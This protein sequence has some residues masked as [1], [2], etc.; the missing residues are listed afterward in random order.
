M[1]L[2]E[3]GVLLHDLSSTDA[4]FQA[5]DVPLDDFKV[6][7]QGLELELEDS[8]LMLKNSVVVLLVV[9][10]DVQVDQLFDLHLFEDVFLVNAGF[11]LFIAEAAGLE[12]GHQ[13][14]VEAECSILVLDAG[15]VIHCVVALE[16]GVLSA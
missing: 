4:F 12:F 15:V 1:L 14:V 9:R 8:I 11:V 10:G 6:L 5:L 16:D 3:Q 7:L 13:R 2:L